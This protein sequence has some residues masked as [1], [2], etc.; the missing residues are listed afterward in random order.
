M[1]TGKEEAVFQ[2][3]VSW[4][5]NTFR[6]REIQAT[7]RCYSSEA[8]GGGTEIVHGTESCLPP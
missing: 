6:E 7:I 4:K 2:N 1:V 5:G 8:G 3:S